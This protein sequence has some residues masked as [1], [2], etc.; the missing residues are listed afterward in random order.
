MLAISRAANAL[1]AL[2]SLLRIISTIFPQ[3]FGMALAYVCKLQ[4]T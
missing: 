2:K 1:V 3:R 4:S